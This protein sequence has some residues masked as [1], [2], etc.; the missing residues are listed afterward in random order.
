MRTVITACALLIL[1]PAVLL[2][3]PGSQF[4]FS[5][6]GSALWRFFDHVV[7]QDHYAF[8]TARFGLIIF[9][10]SD[11]TAPTPI[12]KMYFPDG[13][14]Q[15]ITVQ[16]NYVYMSDGTAGLRIIDVTDLQQPKQVGQYDAT[17]DVLST[18]V[19]G[20]HAYLAVWGQ[21]LRVLNVAIPSAIV[22]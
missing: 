22:E 20:H 1:V 21:G 16:G 15:N 18:A 10:V 14:R 11:S 7:L 19:V 8:C 13:W 2:A 6:E 12:S 17:A 4:A 9:D 5:Y 3:N